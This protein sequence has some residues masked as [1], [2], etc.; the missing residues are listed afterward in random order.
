MKEDLASGDASP[1]LV[2]VA[3]GMGWDWPRKSSWSSGGDSDLPVNPFLAAEETTPVGKSW[4]AAFEGA[5]PKDD[6]HPIAPEREA[7]AED[8][9]AKEAISKEDPMEIRKGAS[10]AKLEA[11]QSQLT[12]KGSSSVEEH[13]SIQNG[14]TSNQSGDPL[15][16]E[17]EPHVAPTSD[18]LAE[19]AMPAIAAERHTLGFRSTHS[20]APASAATSD[21]ENSAPETP[22]KDS[23]TITLKILNGSKVLRSIVLIR[24]CTR[25]AILN[26]ARAYCV[27]RAQDDQSLESQL[28][29]EWDLALVSLKMY[30][31][32]M[33]LSTD[34]V[35]N[36]SWLVRTAEMTGIPRFTLRISEI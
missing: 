13:P 8:A 31:Y 36:L 10:E 3:K 34:K 6:P 28:A 4:Y 20:S 17:P 7:A 32:D 25:T 1:G 2:Y 23:H 35:E 22:T 16:L 33:D 5:S 30:G 27:K 15:E 12:T 26:E 9:F 11:P 21:I 29:K 24:D 18:A 14:H 19:D